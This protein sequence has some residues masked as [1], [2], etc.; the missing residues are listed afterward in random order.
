[1]K[2]SLLSKNLPSNCISTLNDQ[3]L[4]SLQFNTLSVLTI[5]YAPCY[6][7]RR[8]K[9]SAKLDVNQCTVFLDAFYRFMNYRALYFIISQ[10][11]H[12]VAYAILLA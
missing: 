4:C 3:A 1:M 9:S 6:K 8:L 10:K 2:L 7:P 12:A 11:L 5:I